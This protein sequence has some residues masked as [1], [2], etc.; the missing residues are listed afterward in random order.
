VVS[1]DRKVWKLPAI[2][3]SVV[4]PSVEPPDDE[5]DDEDVGSVVVPDTIGEAVV[6]P[7]LAMFVLR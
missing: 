3:W 5:L 7:V 2:V 4:E 1:S 6:A